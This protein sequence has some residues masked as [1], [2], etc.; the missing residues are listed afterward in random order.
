VKNALVFGRADYQ[1][2]HEPCLYAKKAGASSQSDRTATTVWEEDK[3]HDS[4][5]PTQKPV[6]L[7]VRQIVNH[8]ERGEI[9]VDPFAGSGSAVVAAEDTGRRA[10]VMELEPAYVDVIR[11][12]YA[13][14]TG[15]PEYAP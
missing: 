12:R 15:Q 5:H 13:D 10:F 2:R 7:Y 8:A 1:W 6:A 9:V 3:P 4:R 14:Y 11:Q